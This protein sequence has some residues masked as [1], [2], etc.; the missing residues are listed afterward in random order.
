MNTPIKLSVSSI[1]L[2]GIM[3]G[4]SQQQIQPN[5][6]SNNYGGGQVSVKQQVKK[7]LV[8]IKTRVVEKLVCRTCVKKTSKKSNIGLPPAKPGQCYAKVKRPA[9]YKT[10]N[11]RVLTKKATSKRVFVRGPQYGWTT[12]RVLVRAASYT[13]RVIPA[14]YKTVTKRV[15]VKP[16]Y[17][18]WKKGKGLITRIDNNTGEI[19]CRVK[20]PAIYKNV[21]RKVLVRAAQTIKTPRPAVYKNIKRKKLISPAKYKTVRSPA[22]YTT[23]KYRVK[24]ASAK[25]A[26]RQVI[27]QTNAPKHY[28]TKAYTKK[29]YPKHYKTKTYTKKYPKPRKVVKAKPYKKAVK[30]YKARKASYSHGFTTTSKS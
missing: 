2:A 26:W 8:I 17:L 1:L 22:R 24:T 3:A 5:H 19:L 16:S 14:Q 23:K 11:K 18:T 25:Y 4:C 28:K 13:Q 30:K 6:T 9:T 15:M 7:P 12:K 29:K 20:I 10:L 21:S 27:C